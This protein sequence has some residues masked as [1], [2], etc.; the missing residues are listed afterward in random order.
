MKT[1][2]LAAAASLALSA[3]IAAP[4]G[5]AVSFTFTDGPAHSPTAG[6]TVIDNFDTSAGIT[7]SGFQIKTP[8]ADGDGAPP[9][10]SSPAGT[11]YLSVLGN[12]DAVIDFAAV[13][14]PASVS[15][16]QFDWGSLDA[17]NTLTIFSSDGTSSVIPGTTFTNA[18]NGDQHA[19]GTNGLF[20]VVGSGGTTFTGI[21][22]TSSQNSFEIDNLAVGGVPEPSVWAMMLV[23]FGGMGAAMRARR[24]QTAATA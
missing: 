4:A 6:Y 14:G 24:K 21:E 11:P 10:N 17:Y 7:G 2:L 22:L 3:V 13:G 9:A 23:G 16:F 20:T 8:P 12:G 1:I 5:A 18:A 15:S 19:P